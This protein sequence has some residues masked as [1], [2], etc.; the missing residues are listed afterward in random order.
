[1]DLQYAIGWGMIA[2]T[3]TESSKQSKIRWHFL[4]L[5]R[6]LEKGVQFKRDFAFFQP[7]FRFVAKEQQSL[8]TI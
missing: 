1:M 2:A 7:L 5:K 3:D 4:F 6:V 8:K